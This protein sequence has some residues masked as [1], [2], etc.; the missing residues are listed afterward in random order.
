MRLELSLW[1]TV[2]TNGKSTPLRHKWSEF[3]VLCHRFGQGWLWLAGKI[4]QGRRWFF[5][6]V[7]SI[8][9]FC[10]KTCPISANQNNCQCLVLRRDFQNK[11]ARF[12]LQTFLTGFTIFP[13]CMDMHTILSGAIPARTVDIS[14]ILLNWLFCLFRKRNS[15]VAHQENWISLI[16]NENIAHLKRV[17]A[18]R[19]FSVAFAERLKR[20]SGHARSP[21]SRY[22][23]FLDSAS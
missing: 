1:L 12:T 5:I 23:V 2:T 14:N 18:W 17:R 6:F 11:A 7:V 3:C 10:E 8:C 20:L 9:F 16:F 13:P 15:Q 22:T 19:V 21:R 4:L